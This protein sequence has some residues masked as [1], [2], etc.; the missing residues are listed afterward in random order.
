MALPSK[1]GLINRI[2]IK[3]SCSSGDICDEV[4]VDIKGCIKGPE[5]P[6]TPAPTTPSTTTAAGKDILTVVID[7]N[8]V[9][10][11]V[12]PS[13]CM[14]PVFACNHHHLD[15]QSRNNNDFVSASIVDN[16][17]NN[18]F[19]S[20]CADPMVDGPSSIFKPSGDSTVSRSGSDGYSVVNFPNNGVVSLRSMAPVQLTFF[21][22]R[23]GKTCSD[24]SALKV[25]VSYFYLDMAEAT[26]TYFKTN[27]TQYT[28]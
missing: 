13:Y 24:G 20:V 8:C 5:I 10:F 9:V 23:I 1:L 15:G 6:T 7:A 16:S 17:F 14:Y 26:V 3:L 22:L 11:A 27:E 19:I 25:T 18:H 4:A 2:R 12:V 21:S 28:T